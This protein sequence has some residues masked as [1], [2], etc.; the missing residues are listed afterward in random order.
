MPPLTSTNTHMQ[1]LH[2]LPGTI[3]QRSAY[4]SDSGTL[5]TFKTAFKTHFFNSTYISLTPLT[6]ILRLW[7][8][9]LWLMA[10]TKQIH[11]A[12]LIDWLTFFTECRCVQLW[13]G[14][15]LWWWWARRWVWW[16]R[17]RRTRLRRGRT[18]PDQSTAS[19]HWPADHRA[20]SQTDSRLHGRTDHR[21]TYVPTAVQ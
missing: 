12:A 7:F 11:V 1:S 21:W 19:S 10:S 13:S 9:L 20:L 8:T 14:G 15:L 17:R 16:R 4:T 3:G 18:L 5:A 6:A 2:R